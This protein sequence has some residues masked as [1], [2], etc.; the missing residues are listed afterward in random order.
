M[1][2][3]VIRCAALVLAVC[4][5]C[6]ILKKSNPE[7]SMLLA[8]AASVAAAAAAYRTGSVIR[9]LFS[10][11]QKL[12]G[13]SGAYVSSV[14]KCVAIGSVTA[15]SAALCRDASQTALASSIELAGT[16]AAAAVAV[17][18]LIS[19]LEMIGEMV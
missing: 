2:E 17:P 4:A 10:E 6:L 1:T 9:E 5:V 7:L 13:E 16:V 3:N 12:M 18:I 19:L 15:F 11:G 8:A 14:L